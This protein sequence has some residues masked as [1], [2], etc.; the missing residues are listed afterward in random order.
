ML[1]NRQRICSGVCYDGNTFVRPSK[2]PTYK[3]QKSVKK[4]EYFLNQ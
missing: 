3:M 1:S 2:R 4:D